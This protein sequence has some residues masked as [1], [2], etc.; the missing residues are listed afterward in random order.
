MATN[1]IIIITFTL[2]LHT[3]IEFSL[4]SK[5]VEAEEAD[6]FRDF[7]IISAITS[8]LAKWNRAKLFKIGE[9]LKYVTFG[10]KSKAILVKHRAKR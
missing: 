4:L 3:T 1:L 7:A 10:N 6:T 2:Q 5:E 8:S 9:K